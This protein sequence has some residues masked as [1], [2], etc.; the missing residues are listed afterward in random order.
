MPRQPEQIGPYH[1]ESELG[2]GGM[3]TVYRAVDTRNSR[4][5]ALKALPSGYMQDE[6]LERRFQ[7]E[8]EILARLRHRN[9]IHVY[10]TGRTHDF[11]YIAMEMAAGGSLEDRLKSHQAMSNWE[12]SVIIGQVAAGLDYAHSQGLV[13]R[14]IKP[15]NIMFTADGRVVLTDFGIAK[16]LGLRQSQ[17]TIT[18][19]AIGTPAYMSPEQA[20]GREVDQRSD[21]YSLGVVAYHLLTGQVPFSA[22]SSLAV[23]RKITDD[24]VP[25][26]RQIN[27]RLSSEV[28]QVLDRVL[29]KE[30]AAR[31]ATAGSFAQAQAQAMAGGVSDSTLT[32]AT[33]RTPAQPKGRS[34]LA[35]ALIS[36]SSLL[37][38]L[39]LVWLLAG[40]GIIAV[41]GITSG[42]GD[43]VLVS[44][45]SVAEDGDSAG[46][47]HSAQVA[48]IQPTDTATSTPTSPA[49]QTTSPISGV[50]PA[51]E[52]PV[53][54]AEPTAA[55]VLVIAP[56]TE[57]ATAIVPATA[58]LTPAPTE[59]ST[60]QPATPTH[61]PVP[62]RTST[63]TPVP[64][65]VGPTKTPTPLV[66]G[67][68]APRIATSAST[69]S[70]TSTPIATTAPTSTPTR[71]ATS[72][73][74][75]RPTSTPLSSTSAT[76]RPTN[77]SASGATVSITAP[78]LNVRSGPGTDYVVVGSV[79]ADQ[80]YEVIGQ[81]SSCGWLKIRYNN[82]LNAWV[83]GSAQYVSL[84]V[85]CSQIP[86]ASAP[87]T[88]TRGAATATPRPANTPAP[89]SGSNQG[90]IH[91]VNELNAELNIT[92]TRQGGGW[93]T[94]FKVP[95]NGE[96]ER[97]FDPGG[98][99]YTLDAPPPWGST[100]G[101]IDLPAGANWRFPIR[102]G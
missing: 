49:E 86:T 14:D 19:S 70:A 59:T 1:I 56:A 48:V 85:P 78:K 99:T 12:I 79:L 81:N 42:R 91:F 38:L 30:P 101:S 74:T 97:C 2:R 93:N 54:Q 9:V 77:T 71:T 65:A 83:S 94:T 66:I 88:P 15:S 45:S 64:A 33:T 90:C 46:P 60:S 44:G 32:I 26:A 43:G 69:R 25:P 75:I 35:L 89:S 18:G 67:V 34:R 50:S 51:T 72:R 98:Y 40:Q 11:F 21:I 22:T 73:P 61:T 87:P 68:S 102:G 23:L 29:A 31:Y 13:H 39:A 84:A 62:T 28:T 96:M 63:P 5:V 16:N 36:A 76:R 47:T 10:D 52:T 82:L 95:V 55:S 37:A 58:T 6:N 4:V 8:G 7:R 100:N 20:H 80:Q 24:P 17:L 57:T 3:A 53:Q 92:F 41:P 27:P